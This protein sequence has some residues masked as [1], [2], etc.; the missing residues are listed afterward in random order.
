MTRTE[1]LDKAKADAMTCAHPDSARKRRRADSVHGDRSLRRLR[2]LVIEDSPVT[3][4]RLVDLINQSG[5]A[6]IVG[7]AEHGIQG[8]E[9]LIACRPDVVLLDLQLPGI[10]GLDLIPTIKREQPR[11]VLIVLTCLAD[12]ATRARCLSLGADHFFDKA[13]EFEKAIDLLKQLR[14]LAA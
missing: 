8:I 1:G 14:G 12:D 3:R 4:K 11:C 6:E 2:V 7:C 5:A 13:T 10:S 9:M